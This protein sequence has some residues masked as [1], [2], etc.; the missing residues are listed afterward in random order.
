[1]KPPHRGAR[2]PFVSV[3]LVA[4]NALIQIDICWHM[5]GTP[6]GETDAA[7]AGHAISA[8]ALLVTNNVREFKRVPDLLFEDWARPAVE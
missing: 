6:I 8:G 3:P 2:A 5:C 1:M 7:I 4:N